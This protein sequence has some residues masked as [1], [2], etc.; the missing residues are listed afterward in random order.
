MLRWYFGP[1]H[2]AKQRLWRY[3]LNAMRNPRLSVPYA[4]RGVITL[5]YRD[6]LQ[7]QIMEHGSYEP[8]VYSALTERATTGEVFWD[9]GANIGTFTIPALADDRVAM[10]HSFEPEPGANRILREHVRLNAGKSC[11]IHRLALSSGNEARTL[12]YGPEINSGMASLV[13]QPTPNRKTRVVPCSTID[14]LV[15]EKGLAAPTMMK[16]DVEGWEL[17][18]L[19]GASRVLRE[20]PPKTIV[21]EAECNASGVIADRTICGLLESNDYTVSRVARPSGEMQPRENYVAVHRR[22]TGTTRDDAR[23]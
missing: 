23:V 8:E 13:S 17:E 20:A 12:T 18:V 10:I 7:H 6:W 15:Y 19:R 2:I 1:E 22:T 5:D 21:F 9:V 4:G 3:L 14:T 16:V 11:Q